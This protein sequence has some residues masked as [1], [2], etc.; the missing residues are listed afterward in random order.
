MMSM[1]AERDIVM[2]KLSVAL[3]YCIKMSAHRQTLCTIC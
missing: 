1:H 2:A 3:W